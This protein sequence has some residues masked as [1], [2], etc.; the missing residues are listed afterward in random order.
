MAR[1]PQFEPV[2]FLLERKF[3]AGARHADRTL[4]VSLSSGR[5]IR[6][7]P[8]LAVRVAQYRAELLT[9]PSDDLKS[10][11]ESEREKQRAEL[12]AKV[13]HEERE[14]FF[15]QPLARADF[16]HWSKAAH[17]TLDEAVALS[18]GKAPERVNWETVKPFVNVSAFA[19]QYQRR[20]HLALRA[21]Q[22]KQLFDPVLPGVFLAWAKRT[23]LEVS[24]DLEAAVTARGIQVADWKTHYD[25]LKS[26]YDELHQK[27]GDNYDELHKG[28]MEVCED[29]NRIIADLQRQLADAE[30]KAVSAQSAIPRDPTEKPVGT[31]ERDSL[32]KL[33]I[34]MAMGGYGYDPSAGRSEQPAQIATDLA[35]AGVPLDVDTVRKWLKQEFAHQRPGIS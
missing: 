10:L 11:V 16:D 34:G 32:L 24:P 21:K 23:D 15:N 31:R 26:N 19:F 5:R 30:A 7:D 20:R 2:E 33:I 4:P 35:T 28:W 27:W 1:L 8:N 25:D 3:G 18:F 12:A 14:R 17:W 6:T 29:K 13:E 9:L 22:W